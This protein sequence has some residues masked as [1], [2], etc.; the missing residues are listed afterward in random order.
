MATTVYGV[1]FT[2][3]PR[4]AKVISVARGVL[5]TLT[6][7]IDSVSRIET[8]FDFEAFLQTRGPWVGGF[9]FPFG[10]PRELVAAL[11]WPSDWH[12]L[13][14]HVRAMG[15]DEF[16]QAFDRIRESRPVGSR[17]IS[18]KGDARAGS[19]SPMK[20][21]NPP[22]GLM[23][24]EG[25]S[26]LASAG[27]SVMPCAPNDDT[28]IALEAYPGHLARQITKQSYKKDGADGNSAARIAAR[29][30]L[31]NALPTYAQTQWSLN[32]K[33]NNALTAECV[34]DG[35]GDT[36]DAVLCCVQAAAATLYFVQGDERFGIPNEADDF[37]GWIAT[38]T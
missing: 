25:A 31:V 3:A 5:S 18:R 30:T 7:R 13:V 27:V 1:D 36:L 6:L 32:V 12:D 38:V 14:T 34:A 37:E 19:S 23:F 24:F 8:F 35:S 10:L 15:K 33:L 9:D 28:R 21:V 4:K 11:A 29:R 20:L 22:V 2:S 17:Y 26:R 16:K